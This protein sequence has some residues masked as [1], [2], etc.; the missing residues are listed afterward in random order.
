MDKDY[1]GDGVYVSNDGYRI[2]LMVE[3]E[4]GPERVALEPDTFK[5]LLDYA[6]RVM[7]KGFTYAGLL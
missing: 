3:R 6:A 2:W 1:L 7:Y 5:A 4:N